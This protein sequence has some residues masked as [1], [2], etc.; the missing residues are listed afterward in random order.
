M[1][2]RVIFITPSEE[3]ELNDLIGS[4]DE[5]A[6]ARASIVIMSAGG[7]DT[8]GIASTLH[9]CERTVRN[10]ICTFNNNGVSSIYRKTS[11]GRPPLISSE[12][13]S[14]IIRLIY[15]SPVDSGYKK[16]YWTAPLLLK[17]AQFRGIVADISCD[18]LSRELKKAGI[19]LQAMRP[20]RTNSGSNAS[21]NI[22]GRGAPTRNMNAVRTGAYVNELLSDDDR[23][24][25]DRMLNRLQEI[26]STAKSTDR[27]HIEMI[28]Y[29]WV[30][31]MRAL[32]ADNIDAAERIDRL[33]RR[34]QKTLRAAKNEDSDDKSNAP[35]L[36]LAEW[37][38]DL[39]ERYAEEERNGQV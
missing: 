16:R 21:A 4:E 17:E 14:E 7:I 24:E 28:A 39:L 36:T 10:A 8:H 13:R 27:M 2:I 5:V 18:T 15:T 23:A 22:R 1:S 31:L 6:A 30:R 26:V 20:G 35:K 12:Q 9:V 34:Q 29:Y 19:D 32:T 37:A 3:K 33:I 11:P 25:Y 38:T